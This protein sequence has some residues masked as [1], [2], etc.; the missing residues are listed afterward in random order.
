MIHASFKTNHLVPLVGLDVAEAPLIENGWFLEK[1][2]QWCAD[3]AVGFRHIQDPCWLMIS[4]GVKLAN[5]LG[6]IIIQQGNPY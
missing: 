3:R 1:N 5:I 4:S 2:S 6:I